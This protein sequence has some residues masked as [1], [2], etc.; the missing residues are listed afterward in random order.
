MPTVPLLQN[1]LDQPRSLE[2]VSQYQF[3]AGRS[4]LL[5]AAALIRGARHIVLTGMGSSFFACIPLR[6]YLSAHGIP[7]ALLETGELL[8]FH[9]KTL[10]RDTVLVLVSRSGETVEALRLLEAL[11]DTH[12]PVVGV[13]NEEAGALT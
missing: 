11:R 7:A 9:T 8:H 10:T 12:I 6:C 5:E 1:I 13:T 2:R 4:A 3:A